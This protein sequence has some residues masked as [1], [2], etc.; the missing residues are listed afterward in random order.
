MRTIFKMT[1]EL[2]P[3]EVQDHLYVLNT[4]FGGWGRDGT[5][6]W[7]YLEN[8]YGQSAHS[9]VYDDDQPVGCAVFWRANLEGLPAYECVDGAV[10]PS[11]RNQGVYGT[12]SAACVFNLSGEYLYAYPSHITRP[13]LIKAGLN[14]ER[15]F[16]ITFNLAS[17]ML[18]RYNKMEPI[19]DDYVEWRF[20]QH[21]TNKY[22]V[23][24]AGGNIYLLIKRRENMYVVGGRLSQ[25]FGLE[26]LRPP[27]VFSYDFPGQ[28]FRFPRKAGFFLENISR[29]SGESVIPG[30]V[31]DRF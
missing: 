29:Y 28:S 30:C 14:L 13:A 7:K 8:P 3:K 24:R 6:H 31:T 19:P 25:G 9:I 1:N 5:F 2:T 15:R 4:A 27:V 21:P 20:V 11:H 12:A 23:S 16:P 22:Y 26:Q 17:I 10:L 18:R